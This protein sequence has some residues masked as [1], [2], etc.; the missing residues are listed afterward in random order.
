MPTI[1]QIN[2]ACNWGSTGRIAEQ[3]GVLAQKNGWNAY[4]AHGTRYVSGSQLKTIRVSS[5]FEEKAHGVKSLLL[6]AHGL[7]SVNG[8]KA[9]VEKLDEIKPDI[10]HLHN[11]H[12]YFV[13]Y[14]ILFDYLCGKDIP[15]VWTLHD[16]WSFTGH[17]M[18]FDRVGCDK[19]KTGC[20]HCPQ[21]H[22]Y[23]K[24]LFIDRSSA[25]WE[26][27]RK[28]FTSVK[29]LTLVPVS[30]WLGD[31]VS[32]SYLGKYPVHVIH[33]GID[34]N[35]FKPTESDLKKQYGIDGKFV[36]LGVADIFG[37]RKGLGEF[38]QLHQSY[39]DDI[40]IVL[41]GVSEEEKKQLPEG[42]IALRR[43]TNVNQLVEFYS[44]ADVFVNPTYEDNFP[45]T[46]IEALACGTPVITYRTGGSPEAVDENT[47]IVVEKGNYEALVTAIRQIRQ[48]GKASYWNACRKR[49]VEQFNK[50]D[51]FLDYIKL[52]DEVIQ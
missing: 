23:P 29:N 2:V 52:Y 17:C 16:C 1:L 4:L 41:V 18:Y 8:T 43:T 31:L 14:E 26:R 5:S 22:S 15:I 7:G 19:W 37:D 51:R 30:N 11:I 32:Q 13:N 33:N 47:G 25:N 42:I 35:V 3:I 45:T 20:H 49:A 28:L 10:V 44:M 50:D 46:N 21:L 39:G 24:S 36:V 48:K 6:D 34:L 40:Q 38:I 27:K 12:G 9:F